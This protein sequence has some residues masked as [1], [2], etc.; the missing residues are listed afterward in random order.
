MGYTHMENYNPTYE[1]NKDP[2]IFVSS[3]VIGIY[4]RTTFRESQHLKVWLWIRVEWGK[5]C[6]VVMLRDGRLTTYV[7]FKGDDSKYVDMR[8]FCLCTQN[9]EYLCMSTKPSIT[10]I[11]VRERF[12]PAS[13]VCYLKLILEIIF[14]QCKFNF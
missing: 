12:A 9:Q 6:A 4:Q 8:H 3:N 1:K 7:A 5:I 13:V 11:L 2:S 10:L 14:W